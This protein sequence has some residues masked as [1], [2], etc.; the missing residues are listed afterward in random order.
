MASSNN[1]SPPTP[2]TPPKAPKPEEVGYFDPDYKQEEGHTTAKSLAYNPVV[3]VGKHIYYT[4]VYAFVDRLKDLEQQHHEVGVDVAA[5]LRGS[6]L[7]WYSME[8]SELERKGLR[9]NDMATWYDELIKRFKMKSATAMSHLTGQASRFSLTSLKTMKPRTW[10]MHMRYLA[11]A[12]AFDSTYNQLTTMWNQL[13]VQLRRDVP[14][15]GPHTSLTSFLEQLDEKT[16]IWEEMADRQLKHQLLNRQPPY[17]PQNQSRQP[18]KREDKQP[19]HAYIADPD[20]YY[21]EEHHD[22]EYPLN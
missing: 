21:V 8:I 14:M 4:E 12:A 19:P 10:A 5:S 20:D 15:P 16:A 13:D 11:K 17:Q 1:P 3:S 18:I 2:P 6:A 7:A 22:D 9:T